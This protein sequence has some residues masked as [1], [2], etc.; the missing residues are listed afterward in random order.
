MIIILFDSA[1]SIFQPPFVYFILLGAVLF[2]SVFIFKQV[3]KTDDGVKKYKGQTLNEVLQSENL[4]G[5]IKHFGRATPKG[6][7]IHTMNSTKISRFCKAKFTY[8][9]KQN[10]EIKTIE[11]D[12][13]VFR[14]RCSR[15]L[16]IPIIGSF[17]GKPEYFIID[18]KT[19]MVYK[20]KY[21]DTW[22]LS[23]DVFVYQ[24]GGVWVSSLEGKNFLT[25]LIYKKIFENLKEEDM[26]YPKRVVWYNDMAASNMTQVQQIFDMEQEKWRKRVYGET[27]VTPHK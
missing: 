13:L 6:V 25:E 15:F 9:E 10:K 3:R 11:G 26:N 21:R 27:G 4:D 2:I 20:D 24:L 7:L 12:F 17:V 16:N 23:N 1:F 8:K 18:D 22:T 14:T 19:E 5:Y